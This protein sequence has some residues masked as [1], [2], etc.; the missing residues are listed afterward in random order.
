MSQKSVHKEAEMISFSTLEEYM[1]MVRIFILLITGITAYKNALLRTFRMYQK[2]VHTETGM[3][4][5]AIRQGYT[6]K[7]VIYMLRI[8]ITA[9][10]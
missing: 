1:E 2:S 4:S 10:L 5:L 9:V 3:T 6:M 8:T 7:E